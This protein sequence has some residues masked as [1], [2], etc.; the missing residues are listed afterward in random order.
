[1]SSNPVRDESDA[2]EEHK[3]LSI[4]AGKR[5]R[6]ETDEGVRVSK[7]SKAD[8][9]ASS[10]SD[11]DDDDFGP[12]PSAPAPPKSAE[13]LRKEKALLAAKKRKAENAVRYRVLTDRLPSARAYEKSYMHR[14]EITHLLV[15]KT[16]FLITASVD[17]IIKFWKKT[18]P[19]IE[20]VKVFK[21]H[22]EPVVG[23]AAS[24][25]GHLLASISTDKTLK[26][27][28]V[29]SFDMINLISLSFVPSCV[30]FLDSPSSSSATASSSVVAVAEEGTGKVHLFKANASEPF[31]SKQLH[32][33]PVTLMTSNPSFGLVAS[34]DAAGHVEVWSAEPD[35]VTGEPFGHP[36]SVAFKY[37]TE[38]HLYE[39]L[40]A[41]TA[42]TT[43]TFS[44]D[45][46]LFAC[47]ARDNLIR[48]FRTATCK[49]TKKY[50]E[51]VE[52]YTAMQNDENSPY[53]LDS[54]DYG[55]RMAVEK[56]LEKASAKNRLR[57]NVVFDSAGTHIMY[58]TLLGIKV[59]NVETHE[60]VRLLGKEEGNERF[61]QLALFQGVPRKTGVSAEAALGA[62]LIQASSSALEQKGED[63]TLF[64]LAFKRNRFFMFTN[65]EPQA[66]SEGSSRDVLNEK[67]TSFV[68]PR[69]V[70]H[71]Y[72][73]VSVIPDAIDVAVAA[74]SL[75]IVGC[76][77]FVLVISSTRRSVSYSCLHSLLFIP[78]FL[79]CLFTFGSR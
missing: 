9:P 3:K 61:L 1:M 21:A 49:L 46:Q 20:F 66:D 24:S 23:L 78:L 47:T 19:D 33:A 5:H 28:D 18:S 70:S 54:I 31:A 60:L 38:T 74:V 30:C 25:T 42:P 4:L 53:K 51:N 48:V 71:C 75:G 40:K 56:E 50:D 58:S 34:A 43:L 14:T 79:D 68:L 10:E 57:G 37:K 65:R 69:A 76:T 32:N 12:R 55:K 36:A 39:F 8:A 62:G 17:G 41:K 15:T 35:P 72:Y 26:I 13:E 67:V 11:S 77:W 7:S 22:L 27:F 45:G 64:A 59:I 2:E 44:P 29:E 6:D 52:Q 63:P 16:D 73:D